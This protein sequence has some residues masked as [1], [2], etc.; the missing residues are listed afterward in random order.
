MYYK[1]IYLIFYWYTYIFN[2]MLYRYE[3][4]EILLGYS[5]IV[6]AERLERIR[7]SINFTFYLN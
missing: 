7:H 3:T 2:P 5:D 1:Y 4:Q 6:T